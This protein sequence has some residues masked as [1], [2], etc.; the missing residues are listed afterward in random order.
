MHRQAAPRVVWRERLS[1]PVSWWFLGA[2]AVLSVWW[3]VWVVA[4]GTAALLAAAAAVVAVVAGLCTVSSSVVAV[5]APRTPADDDALLA[6]GRARLPVAAIA[7]VTPLDAE[8]R[9]RLAGVDADARAFLLLPPFVTTAV[10]VDLDDPADS[11]PYWL[12]ATRHPQ[13]LC[14]AL[15]QVRTPPRVDRPDSVTD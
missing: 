13:Q 9:Q 4:P 7:A 6:A 14:A 3:V 10:R 8:Q 12:V 11:T 5:Q 2:G 1:A 15:A